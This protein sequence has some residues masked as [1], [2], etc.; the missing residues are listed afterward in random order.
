MENQKHVKQ[1]IQLPDGRN[2]LLIESES[3]YTSSNTP[4][5]QLEVYQKSNFGVRKC[6]DIYED[7]FK[8]QHMLENQ[9]VTYTYDENT[10]IFTLLLDYGDLN[11]PY[12]WENKSEEHPPLWKYEIMLS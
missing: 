4:F 10:R 3:K 2:V 11:P 9:Q 7:M 6:Q 12:Q 8:N 5:Q 1:T